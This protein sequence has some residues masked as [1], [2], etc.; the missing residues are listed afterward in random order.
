M[1]KGLLG[2]ISSATLD[3]VNFQYTPQPFEFKEFIFYLLIENRTNGVNWD[4]SALSNYNCNELVKKP[5]REM[6]DYV[7]NAFFDGKTIFIW[8]KSN[9]LFI[10]AIFFLN[11]KGKL[12]IIKYNDIHAQNYDTNI[13]Y[14]KIVNTIPKGKWKYQFFEA[15]G[16]FQESVSPQDAFY[17]C[18]QQCLRCLKL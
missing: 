16:I 15:Y 1:I 7:L 5:F 6:R 13:T 14:S 4:F 11:Q 3:I 9:L 17:E 8:K 12:K 2:L 18:L 10:Y